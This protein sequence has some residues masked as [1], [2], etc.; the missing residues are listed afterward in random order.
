M[1]NRLVCEEGLAPL[2]RVVE[3]IP[4][5]HEMRAQFVFNLIEPVDRNSL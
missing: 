3:K 2:R 4:N 1:A 5:L